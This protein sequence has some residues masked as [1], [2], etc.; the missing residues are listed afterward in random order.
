MRSFVLVFTALAVLCAAGFASAA[1]VSQQLSQESAIEQVVRRGTLK[2]GMSTFEP[3]AMKDKNGKFIGFEIDVAQRLAK[4][5]G[6]KLQLVPTEWSGI[7]PSLLTGKFDMIIGGMSI[8]ADRALKV[9]FTIP[10]NTTGVSMVAHKDKAKGFSSTDDFNKS[11][12]TLVARTGTSAAAAA[13]KVMPKARLLLFDQ[14]PQALQ[15]LL[16]GNAHAFV[17]SAPKPAF[18]AVKHDELF[19]PFSGTFTSEPNA[20]AVRKGDPDTL[21]VLNSWIRA[22]EAEGWFK[23]RFQYWF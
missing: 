2:V 13:K 5:L 6:V 16:N 4:D 12:V 14:E 3:W 19:L 20:I 9:N 23:E 7:I 18:E 21:N 1:K 22:V 15:E 11:D 10:Y 17:S 8:R